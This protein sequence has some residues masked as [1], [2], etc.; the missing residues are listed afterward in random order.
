MKIMLGVKDVIKIYNRGI[1][2]YEPK[3][4]PVDVFKFDRT[5]YDDVVNDNTMVKVL[6]Y[7]FPN[8]IVERGVGTL[9]G[10]MTLECTVEGTY[11][12]NTVLTSLKG[13]Y[14]IFVSETVE[15][16]PGAIN[17]VTFTVPTG[18][19]NRLG[20]Y[21]V[22]TSVDY[23]TG[24]VTCGSYYASNVAYIVDKENEY[25]YADDM[26]SI[27]RAVA[28][29][30]G[31]FADTNVVYTY[32]ED[33][34]IDY[35]SIDV[36][37]PAKTMGTGQTVTINPITYGSFEGRIKVPNSDAILNGF[38]LY[39]Y[40]SAD[41]DSSYEIDIEILKFEGQWN[42][43][44]T[45]HNN[46]HESHGID[47]TLEPGEIFQKRIALLFDPSLDYHNYKINFYRYYV[48][49]E[50]DGIEVARWDGKFVYRDMSLYVGNFYTHWLSKVTSPVD[51]Q[52]SVKWIRRNYD[53]KTI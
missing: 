43:W 23:G 31:S 48:T 16:T 33:G 53:E 14:K 50:I 17:K 18:P 39:G 10:V 49:F 24:S 26:I 27:N 30:V 15:L 40:D 51:Q 52:M 47:P 22:Y 25:L 21:N 3:A 45:I 5:L 36:N 9:T 13:N 7:E 42:M 19:A 1:V 4:P 44:T 29:G 37:N 38:F 11:Q 12:I 41:P 2:L 8:G 20:F 32:V 34:G 6:G 35:H 46:K 28:G